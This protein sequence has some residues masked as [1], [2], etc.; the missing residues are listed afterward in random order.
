MAV[1]PVCGMTV[2]PARAAGSF[3][4]EGTTYYFCSNGCL[5]KFSA[6]PQRFLAG[7]REPMMQHGPVVQIGGLKGT[8]SSSLAS[9]SSLPSA[10]SLPPAEQ[11]A[12]VQASATTYTCP[13]HPEIVSDKPGA[14]PIC[15]MALEPRVADLSDTPNPELVDMTRRFWIGVALGAPVFLLSMGDMLSGG[16]VGRRIP[17]AS[18]NWIGLVLATPV[19]LWCGSPF[20]ERMWQ[21]FVNASPNMFTLIGIGVGAAYGYSAIATAAP[22]VFPEGFR[23]HGTVDTYFDTAIVITV[24]VLLGQV[25]ELRARHRTGA[26]IRQLLGLAPKTARV[27]RHGQEI[28]VPLEHVRPGDVVRVRPGEKIPVD[29]AVLDGAAAVDESMV[30]GESIPVDKQARDRVIGAT[31]VVN[32]TFTMR[33]ERVGSETLL[34]QIVR[35]VAEAQRT[36]APIQRLADRVAEYFVPAVVVSA[37]VTFAVWSVWGPDPRLAHGLVNAVAVLIIACPCALGL[38]TPMAIMVGAGQGAKAGVLIKNAE[39]LELLARVDTLVL[40]KTGTLTEG[41]PQVTAIEPTDGTTDVDVLRVAAA[42]ERGSEH[43][44]AAAIVRAAQARSIPIPAV[45]EFRSATGLGV[46]G[47]VDGRAVDLGS[48]DFVASRGVETAALLDRADVLRQNGQTVICVALDGRVVGMMAVADPIRSTT[49]E[50]I[51]QLKAEGLRIV[52][53]TG[54]NEVTANAI[55]RRLGID[56]VHAEV[57]PDRKREIVVE[58]RRGGHQVAM[59]GDGINDA[60]ALAA[61]TVGI[62]M[63]TGT[64]VAIESAAI[65]LV[66]GD[67]RGIVRARRLSRRTLR[68][69]RQNL[70]LAFVYNTLGVPIAAGV[71]YPFA[72]LLISPIWASAAMT[73]SSLSVIANALRLRRVS[74]L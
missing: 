32:G 63:G 30:T 9:A 6:D 8:H 38:A 24:L 60:P 57:Q 13:M 39:A 23:M 36:R 71:L 65:T 37:F 18:V 43:P 64:D 3:E 14:C 27:V 59:A 45:S 25:L 2:D 42:V 33:A 15:G 4:Y 67:L 54:D 34:A 62:A 69:I 46:S 20:F 19:V 61:A 50:A 52:M 41:R 26:A 7:I 31:I 16:A 58:L 29:G 40:D 55:A 51:G 49:A 11:A 48:I 56:E 66:K 53:L 21:S 72:G 1:D 22:N 28:D 47:R 68:N 17:A 35:M 10:P 12:P 70:F 5:A 74:L 73:M 44:L